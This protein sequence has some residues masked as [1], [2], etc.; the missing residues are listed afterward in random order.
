MT[1]PEPHNPD[2]QP[3]VPNAIEDEPYHGHYRKAQGPDLEARRAQPDRFDL[4]ELLK[5]RREALGWT[6][7]N[8]A[9][10]TRV[11]RSYLEALEQAAYDVLPP[12]AF[13]L[14]FVKAYA[15]ALG[16]DDESLADM[17]RR[18][19]SPQNTK[20][21]APSGASLE[22]AKPSYRRY[23]VA[24][25]GLVAVIVAWNIW[26]RQPAG[27]AHRGIDDVAASSWAQGVPLIRDGV[28]YV[29]RPQAAPPDQD[30]PTPYVTPGLE[31]QFASIDAAHNINAEAP[32]PDAAALD[33]RKAFN[34]RGAVYG[35]EPEDSSV[36]LQATKSVNLVL[37][38]PAGAIYFV[39]QF[40]PGEAYRLPASDQQNVLLDVSD[41]TAFDM[42]YN[43]EYA[44]VMEAKIT[45]VG[46]ANSRAMQLS[47]ALDAHEGQAPVAARPAPPP[48]VVMPQAMPR[49]DAPIPYMPSVRKPAPASAGSPSSSPPSASSASVSSPEA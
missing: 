15:K 37:R 33:M 27:H 44:G 41:P 17:F 10:I 39:H 20:L 31:A 23:F 22:D 48:P 18:E 9:E 49:S 46:K 16:L 13:A 45:P 6:L 3:D 26:Q 43:G 40:A 24:A 35:A 38:D 32:A 8:V 7:D 34:P 2:F 14:G 11:K 42:F 28:V 36:T 30:V 19:V 25:G 29:T 12:R 4:A 47:N 1:P 5:A 21:H